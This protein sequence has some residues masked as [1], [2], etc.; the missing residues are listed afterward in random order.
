MNRFEKAFYK[1]KKWWSIVPGTGPVVADL[2]KNAGASAGKE[3]RPFDVQKAPVVSRVSAGTET[4][5]GYPGQSGEPDFPSM[6]AELKAKAREQIN[7]DSPAALWG[8]F[9]RRMMA[10]PV[11]SI[12]EA[13]EWEIQLSVITT[14]NF[15]QMFTGFGIPNN[16]GEVKAFRDDWIKKVGACEYDNLTPGQETV[17]DRL[18]DVYERKETLAAMESQGIMV[19]DMASN[20]RYAWQV[21]EI[22]RYYL[23]S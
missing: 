4:V 19:S 2:G 7:D 20:Q 22:G 13:W 21:A 11:S 10:T 18:I 9:Q 6:L 12:Q 14:G 1:Y 23:K 15:R 8:Y 5:P 3:K 16:D 17:L